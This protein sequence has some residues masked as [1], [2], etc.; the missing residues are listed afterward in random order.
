MQLRPQIFI[1]LNGQLEFLSDQF[2]SVVQLLDGLFVRMR[3]VEG[4]VMG[5]G[6]GCHCGMMR[7]GGLMR[8][9]VSL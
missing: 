7:E 3:Y 6:Q 4:L 1:L 5:G 8:G 9:V 2:E